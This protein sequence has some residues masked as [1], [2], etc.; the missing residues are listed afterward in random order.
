MQ[1]ITDAPGAQ[2]SYPGV[3]RN[4]TVGSGNTVQQ[5]HKSLSLFPGNCWAVLQ[6]LHFSSLPG[7]CRNLFTVLQPSHV[8]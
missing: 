7:A 6:P 4:L 3:T 5:D 1:K 8:H 2:K